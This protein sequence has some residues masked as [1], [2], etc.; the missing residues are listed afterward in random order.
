MSASINKLVGTFCKAAVRVVDG[1]AR[2]R[3]AAS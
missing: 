3:A 2:W 1:D